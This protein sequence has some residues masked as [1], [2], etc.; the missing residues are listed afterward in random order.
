MARF[1]FKLI[2]KLTGKRCSRCKH[3]CAGR[4]VHPREDMFSKCW[5]NPLRPGFEGKGEE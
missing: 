4:C 5:H 3:N 2:G 1:I